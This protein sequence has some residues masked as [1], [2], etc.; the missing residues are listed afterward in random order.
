LPVMAEVDADIVG[1]TRQVVATGEA[2]VI[3]STASL[4]AEPMCVVVVYRRLGDESSAAGEAPRGVV[5]GPV[6]FE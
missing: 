6:G 1:G 5:A 3:A 4:A 2:A